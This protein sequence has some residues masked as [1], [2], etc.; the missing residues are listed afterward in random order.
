MYI[1]WPLQ[2]FHLVSSL[3]CHISYHFER[4]KT[5]ECIVFPLFHFPLVL[6]LSFTFPPFPFHHFPFPPLPFLPFLSTF[7][8]FY[9]PSPFPCLPFISTLLPSLSLYLAPLFHHISLPFLLQFPKI[10][11]RLNNISLSLHYN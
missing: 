3:F 9:F 4:E 1:Q 5:N 2:L 7:F 8:S 10:F 6:L 11:Q